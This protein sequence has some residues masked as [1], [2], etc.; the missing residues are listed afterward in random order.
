MKRGRRRVQKAGSVPLRQRSAPVTLSQRLSS[1]TTALLSSDVIFITF[2]DRH[3]AIMSDKRSESPDE[4]YSTDEELPLDLFENNDFESS[5][6]PKPTQAGLAT[7]AANE[8]LQLAQL[9]VVVPWERD[10][11]IIMRFLHPTF[12]WFSEP[13]EPK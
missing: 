10:E 6:R 7:E 4:S 12:L 1:A 9:G 3:T 2:F 13:K 11:E 8:R 5:N